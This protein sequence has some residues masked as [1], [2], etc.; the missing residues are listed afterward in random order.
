MFERID[1]WLVAGAVLVFVI[2]V[3]RQVFKGRHG[4]K[5]EIPPI[6]WVK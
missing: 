5:I 4:G 6:T 1:I 2:L 3:R